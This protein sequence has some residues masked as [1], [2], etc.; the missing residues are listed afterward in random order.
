MTRRL[1]LKQKDFA[2]RFVE[3]KGNASKA[4][5]DVYDVKNDHVARSIGAENLTKPVIIAEIQKLLPSDEKIAQQIN[6]VLDAKAKDAPSWSEKHQ[7][8]STALRLKGYLTNDKE[9]GN[10]NIALVIQQN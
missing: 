2:R 3:T 10:T 5:M 7:F 9:S 8:I 6:A 4:A 1:S